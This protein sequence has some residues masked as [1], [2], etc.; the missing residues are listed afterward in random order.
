[1]VLPAP[2]SQRTVLLLVYN[3]DLRS[4]HTE[5][6]KLHAPT[7]ISFTSSLLP[8]LR[9]KEERSSEITVDTT[10]LS[11]QPHTYSAHNAQRCRRARI[12]GAGLP[13]RSKNESTLPGWHVTDT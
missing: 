13:N 11:I 9:H 6:A 5:Q 1:M 2:N 10:S 12:Y 4:S 7:M 8:A 3:F